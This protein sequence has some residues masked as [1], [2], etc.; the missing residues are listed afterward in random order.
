MGLHAYGIN[1]PRH[2]LPADSAWSSESA[3]MRCVLVTFAMMWGSMRC[4]VA[5]SS[6]KS[7]FLDRP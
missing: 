7:I 1:A 2:S 5:M 6:G 4:L 3:S